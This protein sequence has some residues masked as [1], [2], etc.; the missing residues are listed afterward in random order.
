M[1]YKD[2]EQYGLIPDDFKIDVIRQ[3]I[4]DNNY[5][6][7]VEISILSFGISV[8]NWSEKTLKANRNQCFQILKIIVDKIANDAK[9]GD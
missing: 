6:K 7:G 3:K 9:E 5:A 4:F 1:D 8:K 2:F